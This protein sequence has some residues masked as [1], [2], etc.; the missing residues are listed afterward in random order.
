[1]KEV[2]CEEL[3]VADCDF[4]ARGEDAREAAEAMVAHL[5]EAHDIDMPDV[6][7]IVEV[8]P[9][10]ETFLDKLAQLITPDPD[11]ETQLAVQRL[12]QAL[13]FENEQAAE[14]RR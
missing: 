13:D 2:R 4:V 1:M 6:D 3:G 7:V 12:R 9:D 14:S 5:E 10:R 8:Y 11:K